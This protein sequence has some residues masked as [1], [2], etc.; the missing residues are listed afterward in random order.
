MTSFG[1]TTLS[2]A[3]YAEKDCVLPRYDRI[4]EFKHETGT[5]HL[6]LPLSKMFELYKPDFEIHFELYDPSN[7]RPFKGRD[8]KTIVSFSPYEAQSVIEFQETRAH[9][10]ENDGTVG[11]EIKR[12]GGC[13]GK[14]AISYKIVEVEGYSIDS[15]VDLTIEEG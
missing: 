15:E 6:N 7:K 1:T 10:S 3:L 2:E 14:L 5:L 9:V 11:L 8:C 13:G 4:V 12:K